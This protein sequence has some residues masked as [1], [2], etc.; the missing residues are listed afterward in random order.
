MKTHGEQRHCP[1]PPSEN[2]NDLWTSQFGHWVATTDCTSFLVVVGAWM[3]TRVIRSVADKS[4]TAGRRK[5][6]GGALRVRQHRQAVASVISSVAVAVLYVWSPVD[7][8]NTLG[9]RSDTWSPPR[10]YWVR[11]SASVPNASFRSVS[12][13]SSHRK[14]VRLR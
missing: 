14:A 5:R 1:I 8:V 6:L 13:S 4:A 9:Y 3:A 12:V 11:L 2:L 7:I 10:R